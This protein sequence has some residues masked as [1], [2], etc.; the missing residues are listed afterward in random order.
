MRKCYISPLNLRS[1]MRIVGQ[2]F[3]EWLLMKRLLLDTH[4]TYSER[5]SIKS[6]KPWTMAIPVTLYCQKENK[7]KLDY[8]RKINK[9]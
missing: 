1:N 8:I 4:K 6:R 3:S 7:Q 5:L 2:L 9:N